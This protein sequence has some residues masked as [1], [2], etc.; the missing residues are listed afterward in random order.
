MAIKKQLILALLF[1]SICGMW[2]A[3][4][5]DDLYKEAVIIGG[6]SDKDQWVGKKDMMLK[7]SLG[8]EYYKKF[9]DEYGDFLTLDIQ[10]RMA[11]DSKEDKIY[12]N[13]KIDVEAALDEMKTTSGKALALAVKIVYVC[14]DSIG[15]LL[16]KADNEEKSLSGLTKEEKKPEEKPAEKK[17]EE[18]KPEEVKEAV[19]S[20]KRQDAGEGEKKEEKKEEKVEENKPAEEKDTQPKQNNQEEK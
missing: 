15:F 10:I 11:Y 8:F 16:S 19:N 20:E 6:Y 4:R 7:N 1:V 18:P 14:K 17:K 3:V 2:A 13:I 12:E 9:S 5:A